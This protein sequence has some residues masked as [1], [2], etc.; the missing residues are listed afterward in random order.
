MFE[1]VTWL[2]ELA[3]EQS[4]SS[5]RDHYAPSLH[6]Y[7]HM[8]DEQQGFTKHLEALAD[9]IREQSNRRPSEDF[10]ASHYAGL[11]RNRRRKYVG[12]EHV[13][14]VRKLTAAEIAEL[15]RHIARLKGELTATVQLRR[16]AVV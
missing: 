9:E 2:Q 12:C 11:V 8:S 7:A 5:R 14:A 15:H 10:E 6:W 4:R 1:A 13:G 16:R 3:S